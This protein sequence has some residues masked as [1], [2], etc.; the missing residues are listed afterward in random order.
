MAQNI[1]FTLQ[2]A[3]ASRAVQNSE[4]CQRIVATGAETF[5]SLGFW[6]GATV[7]FE[8]PNVRYLYCVAKYPTEYSDLHLPTSFADS[9][10]DGF[11]D[12]TI[13]IEAALVAVGRGARVIEKHFTLNKGLPG[14]D[15][16]C[17]VTPE[18]LADLARYGR[19]MEKVNA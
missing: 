14:P 17:S 7:P 10:Y 19:L 16:V 3:V 2:R 12:H 5:A 1:E 4:L 13:G 11:S 8:A 18:E 9:V 6:D 15:H